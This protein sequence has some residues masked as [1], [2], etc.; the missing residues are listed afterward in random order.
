MTRR[1]S[2]IHRRTTREQIEQMVEI[3][4]AGMLQAY[5]R[6]PGE[7]TANYWRGVKLAHG[8]LIANKVREAMPGCRPGYDYALGIY[9]PLPLVREIPANYLAQREHIDIDGTR[10]WFCGGPWQ[11]CQ[12][13]H[14]RDL[15]EVDGA[16]WKRYLAWKRSG[17]QPRY[18]TEEDPIGTPCGIIRHCCH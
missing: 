16:E 1:I 12:A 13:E 17:F 18:H 8:D 4:A 3:A 5:F 6:M 11:R 14:L 10:H 2:R 9:P 15:G 7:E